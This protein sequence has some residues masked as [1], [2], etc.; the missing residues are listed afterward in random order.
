LINYG[1]AAASGET[2][3]M[4]LEALARNKAGSVGPALAAETRTS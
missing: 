3:K 1:S 4:S 2:R